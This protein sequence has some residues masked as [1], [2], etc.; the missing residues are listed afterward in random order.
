MTFRPPRWSHIAFLFV[1]AL[2]STACGGSEDAPSTMAPP[3]VPPA[4]RILVLGDGGSEDA[5][6]DILDS[7]G[8]AVDRG[9][10]WYLDA[11][12]SIAEYA[13]V[14]MLTGIDYIHSMADSAQTRLRDYVFAG[15]GLLVTEW[16]NYYSEQNPLLS[17]VMPVTDTK[18]YGNGQET[19]SPV[20]DHPITRRLPASFTTGTDWSRATLNLDPTPT[21][22]ATVV[23]QG[24]LGGPAM[25]VGVHGSGRIVCWGMAGEYSG[26]DIWT[27]P[28]ELLLEDAVAWAAKE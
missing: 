11:G 28:L 24:L 18:N 15:G 21:K 6:I 23:L 7:A 12:D 25:V 5:V 22:S 26:P 8:F 27:D 10:P 13:A 20:R 17:S 19:C 4:T 16:F 9:G 3:P 14:V 2:W 1:L